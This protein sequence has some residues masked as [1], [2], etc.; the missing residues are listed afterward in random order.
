MKT[1]CQSGLGIEELQETIRAVLNQMPGV[2]QARSTSY[3][4]VRGVL[5]QRIDDG[6]HLMTWEDFRKA[7]AE[8]GEEDKRR[9]QS[10]AENLNALGVALYYGDDEHLRDTRV[11]NPN[12]AA[13]GLYGL[14][15]GVNQMPR[16]GRPGYLWAAEFNTVLAEGMANMESARGARIADYPEERGGV[17]VHEFLLDLMVDRELGFQAGTLGNQPVYLLPGLLTL[18]E[19]E[20]SEYDVAAHMDQAEVRFCYLYEVLPV[21]VMSRFIVRTHPLSEKLH[22]W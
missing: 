17:N 21:G 3:C 9:Q 18:D 22:R 20:P 8:G 15:R 5:D 13:N 14:V 10:M 2:R 6:E 11:L 4:N 12:W 7:C 1:D 19:L 16:N